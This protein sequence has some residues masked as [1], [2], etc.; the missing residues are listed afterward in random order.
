MVGWLTRREYHGMVGAGTMATGFSLQD[1]LPELIKLVSLLLLG[2]LL[3]RWLY[4][5]TIE[6]ET[7]ESRAE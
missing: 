5:K 2:Y 1:A 4:Y 6:L 3:L 7:T